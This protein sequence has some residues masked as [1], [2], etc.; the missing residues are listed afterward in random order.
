MRLK[1][2]AHRIRK[3]RAAANVERIVVLWE[4]VASCRLTCMHYP[5]IYLEDSVF[6]HAIL[7]TPDGALLLFVCPF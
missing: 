3:P 6:F 2:A 5:V 1:E 4:P 7:K